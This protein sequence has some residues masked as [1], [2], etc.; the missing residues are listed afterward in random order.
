MKG[1]SD[2]MMQQA[3]AMQEKMQKIQEDI[4]HIEVVGESGAGMIK[5]TMTGRHEIKNVDLAPSLLSED[6]E[7]I[8]D[9]FAAAVNDAVRRLEVV[10]KEKINKLGSGFNLPPGFKLP[11]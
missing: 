2:L 10:N 7:V 8:E 5:V 11:F 1:L 9:L 3:Q 4:A 6:K